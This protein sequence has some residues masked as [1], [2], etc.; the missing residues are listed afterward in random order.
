MKKLVLAFA[1]EEVM[2][3]KDIDLIE[4]YELSKDIL[5]EDIVVCFGD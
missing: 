5:T 1:I 4:K 3:Y 2:L